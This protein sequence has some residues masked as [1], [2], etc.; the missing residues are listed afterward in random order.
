MKTDA[1]GNVIITGSFKSKYLAF[2][3][4]TVWN[5]LATTDAM[6]VIKYDSAGN[7][8]WANGSGGGGYQFGYAVATDA[9]G[10]VFVSGSYNSNAITFGDSTLSN[11][12]AGF[13][14]MFLVKYNAAGTVQWARNAAGTND[15]AASAMGTDAHGN[16][17]VA[18]NFVSSTL[19]F[20]TTT[21]T[22]HGGTDMFVVKY[23]NAGTVKW[24]KSNGGAGSEAVHGIAIDDTAGVVMTGNYGSSS[25]GFGTTTLT[26]DSAGTMDLFIAKYDSLGN[27]KWAKTTGGPTS[28]ANGVATYPPGNVYVT[29]DFSD[30]TF[31]FGTNVLLNSIN[32]GSTDLFVARYTQLALS[33]PMVA[34]QQHK[35]ALYPNP[36]DGTINAVLDETGYTNISVFDVTG[37][38]V[39]QSPLTGTEKAVKISTGALKSGVY[40]LRVTRNDGVQSTTF[41]ISR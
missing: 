37:R 32:T 19:V 22:N 35:I 27:I 9:A 17:Y 3:T 34:V 18:G 26:N 25:I 31:S 6:F 7:Y 28:N 20:G 14:D 30:S 5:S 36:A 41:V 24:A 16:V 23:N 38:A 21:L 29:G 13:D 40:N 33:V 1:A 12:G 15:D 4:D 2:G 10:N 11:S 8:I 39:Y